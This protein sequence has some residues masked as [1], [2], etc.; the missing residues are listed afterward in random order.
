MPGIAWKQAVLP[1]SRF[2]VMS[3]WWSFSTCQA[4]VV[5]FRISV[6]IA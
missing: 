6:Y 3:S 5:V 1:R 4:P 2:D